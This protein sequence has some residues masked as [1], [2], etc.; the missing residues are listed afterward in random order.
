MTPAALL[1]VAAVFAVAG[2]LARPIAAFARGIIVGRPVL[3]PP[4]C[5]GCGSQLRGAGRSLPEACPE[6]GRPTGDPRAVRRTRPA[7]AHDTLSPLRRSGA[8][9]ATAVVAACALGVAAYWAVAV[10]RRLPSPSST[11]GITVRPTKG[12][13]EA[14]LR[15]ARGEVE[16]L[17][18]TDMQLV[19]NLDGQDGD[20]LRAF[21]EA[22]LEGSRA[23]DRRTILVAAAVESARRDPASV[24]TLRKAIAERI[25]APRCIATTSVAPGGEIVV[26]LVQPVIAAHAWMAIEGARLDGAPLPLSSAQSGPGQGLLE[27]GVSATSQLLA[28]ATAPLAPGTYALEIDWS[29]DWPLV[30]PNGAPTVPG[31][32]PTRATERRTL[33]VAAAPETIEASTPFDALSTLQFAEQPYIVLMPPAFAEEGRVGAWIRFPSMPFAFHGTWSVRTPP[34]A[35]D[36]AASPAPAT[37]WSPLSNLGFEMSTLDLTAAGLVPDPRLADTESVRLRFDPAPTPP[38]RP[39]ESLAATQRWGATPGRARDSSVREPIEFVFRRWPLSRDG[40]TFHLERIERAEPL[41]K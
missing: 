33:V 6:C 34:V 39:P 11:G 16:M 32:F 40:T 23:P 19:Q 22:L 27:T 14:C 10:A 20:E 2:A 41:P 8:L 26:A 1:V 4:R 7:H 12:S 35:C 3:M 25:V 18:P 21:V 30:G 17:S 28:S 29:A 38:T 13:H 5:A 15:W 31:L 36:A 37:V 9:V 24:P